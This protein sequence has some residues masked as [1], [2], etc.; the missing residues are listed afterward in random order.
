LVTPQELQSFIESI[1]PKPQILQETLRYVEQGELA[2]AA[3]TASQDMVLAAYLRAF[4]NRPQFFFQKEVKELGQIFGIL[5]TTG[6]KELLY[7]YMLHLFMPNKW[8]LFALNAQ[9]FD[10]LQTMLSGYW[11]RIIDAE[12]ITQPSIIAI[13]SL[14][15]AS[16]I[17]TEMLFAS[18]KKEVE[19]LKNTKNIDYNTILERLIGVNLFDLAKTIGQ[20]WEME[21]KSLE[22]LVCVSGKESCDDAT[23]LKMA[24]YM[25]LLFFYV[26]SK[27]DYIKS[28][29]NDFLEFMPEFVEPIY[30][31][32]TK[33]VEQK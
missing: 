5:G 19:L 25:H 11:R 26:L 27:P 3:N 13:I 20:T 4:V 31:S 12:K 15:P 14:L 18:H 28:G 9:R 16:I 30:E 21:P 1:P 7:H 29:L 24:R 23:L 2:K 8:E 17:V 6:A 33:I 22:L 10:E 32:F